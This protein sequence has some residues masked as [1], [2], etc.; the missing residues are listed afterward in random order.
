[1]RTHR[2]EKKKGCNKF[3]TIFHQWKRDRSKSAKGK[4]KMASSLSTWTKSDRGIFDTGT[5]AGI[6]TDR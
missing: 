1:M 5:T 3:E 4:K 2:K 6:A